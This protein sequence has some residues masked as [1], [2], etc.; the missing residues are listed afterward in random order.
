MNGLSL[1]GGVI[2]Y[3]GTFL[4]F[5]DY[6][7][8]AVRL[9]ALS[10]RQVI[11]VYT[12]DS[13]GLGEDGPTHQPVEHFPG[14]RAIPGMSF[15]RPADAAETVEAWRAA[16]RQRE[17]PTIL[18]LSRQALPVLD[19]SRFAPAVG[20]HQGAYVLSDAPGGAP[21]VI[22][23]ATGSEV[24]II[25]AA[26]QLLAERGVRARLVSMPS[27]NLFEQQ[28][29]E[30][31]ESVLPPSIS[32]RVSIEA[33]VTLGWERYVGPQ[34][35]MIGVNRFGASSPYKTIYQHYGLT[36]QKVV[37]AAVAAIEGR[38]REWTEAEE[39]WRRRQ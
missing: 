27:W 1:H 2:P 38:G 17:G 37:E 35:A 30:Y 7:K 28:P 34:G 26:Q 21:Q 6:M 11:F 19:R 22:L 16:L 14:L 24:E 9:A 32:A 8:N 13:I 4:T 15:I 20:L 23:I 33:A 3:G 36:P 10:D 31:R 29:R 25:V 5:S 18:A 39:E 12:H